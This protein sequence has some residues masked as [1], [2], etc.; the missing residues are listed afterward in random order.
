MMP[1]RCAGTK[2]PLQICTGI[3][4]LLTS[5]HVHIMGLA[6]TLILSALL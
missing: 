5:S 1:S 3:P 4:T 6:G 2:G